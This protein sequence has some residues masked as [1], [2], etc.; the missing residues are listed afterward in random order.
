MIGTCKFK[1]EDVGTN[2]T[3]YLDLA[4]Q[5]EAVLQ[6]GVAMIGPAAV[7]IDA[8][9][10]SFQLYKRGIYNEPACSAT[11]LDHDVLVVGYGSEGSSDIGRTD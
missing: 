5:D 11:Q 9:H 10:S 3:V 4:Q 2:I 1:P 8:S 7:A 6:V